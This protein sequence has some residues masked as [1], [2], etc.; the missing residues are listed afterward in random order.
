MS[1]PAA[2][3]GFEFTEK[4]LTVAFLGIAN[5]AGKSAPLAFRDA[6][7]MTSPPRSRLKLWHPAKAITEKN[8]GSAILILTPIRR[9]RLRRHTAV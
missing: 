3:P 5:E 7:K 6:F 1:H 2:L 9:Q 4:R 8:N